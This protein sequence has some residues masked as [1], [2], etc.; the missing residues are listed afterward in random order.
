M[1]T[2]PIDTNPAYPA[3]TR[4]I[5]FIAFLLISL[6]FL[7]DAVHANSPTGNLNSGNNSHSK[8]LTVGLVADNEPY[9]SIEGR[10]ARGFSVDLLNKLS[11]TLD[12]RFDYRVGSWP[13]IYAAFL[14]GE[15]DIID[16]ISWREDRAKKILFTSPY[17]LR[18]AVVMQNSAQPLP[19]VKTLNDLKPYR[20]GILRDVY[21]SDYLVAQGI[22]VIE[23]D[24][25]PNLVQA[26]AFGW[27]DT[28]IGPEITLNYMARRDGF[29][30][31]ETHGLAPLNGLEIE[32][33]RLGTLKNRPELF[34]K[35]QAGLQSL[36]GEWLQELNDRWMQNEGQFPL[37]QEKLKLSSQQRDY[38]NRLPPLRVGL[39][40][41]YAPFS[42]SENG[43]V[44][45]L[46][47]DI[48]YRLHDLTG[49][50]FVP[51]VDQ[52]SNL[53]QLFRQ[54]DLD[55]IAN[56]SDLPE[57]RKF[58]RFTQ[59]YHR[60][61]NVAFTRDAN[62]RLNKA[63]DLS[64]LRIAVG[65][66]V[67][68]EDAVRNLFPN[69]VLSY[70][71]QSSMFKALAENQVDVVLTAL[72][73]GNHWVR[74]LGMTDTWIAGELRLPGLAGED[75]RLGMQPELEPLRAI[76]DQALISL[77]HTEKRAIEN[78]WLGA[79][80]TASGESRINLNQKEQELLSNWDYT[81]TYCV[82]PDRYPLEQLDWEN[83]HEGMSASLLTVLQQK[84]DNLR[85]DLYATNSWQETLTALEQGQCDLIPMIVPSTRLQQNLLFS[86]SWYNASNVILGNLDSPFINGINELTDKPIGISR[87]NN[88]RDILQQRYPQLKL[89]LVDDTLGGI[90]LVRQKKLYGFIGGLAETSHLLQQESLGDIRV[91]GRLPVDSNFAVAVNRQLPQLQSL[92]NKLLTSLTPK[93]LDQI[94]NDWL[95][96][97][98]EQK[99]DYTTLWQLV[100]GF[101]LLLLALFFWNRKLGN[102]NHQLTQANEQLAYLSVTDQLTELGNRSYLNQT[103]NTFI[104]Q[105]HKEGLIPACAMIDAD[106]FKRINDNHGHDVGDTCLK[107]LA[108]Q[109]RH[110]FSE[111]QDHLIRF[112][113]EEFI[114]LTSARTAEHIEARLEQL[115]QGIE[116]H[117]I[118]KE[119]L[120]LSF[121]ISIGALIRPAGE[122]ESLDLWLKAADH[123]LYKAKNG[124]RNRLVSLTDTGDLP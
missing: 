26:L 48:L 75:L 23:Y 101:S 77:S 44:Q 84:L 97:K 19:P 27:V 112:G 40:R 89:R 17:H 15:L 73:N 47:V 56:I 69:S 34:Q 121:T 25:L 49:V 22:E 35:L 52:W 85:F 20:V 100:G 31:L 96:I 67:F 79:K 104:R 105:C 13:D 29:F 115:R 37:R 4:L 114:V 118:H 95:A 76:L 16:G 7:P 106:H 119:G 57:R 111:P 28:I 70:T 46:S 124:G 1:R 122:H 8:S 90:Q 21:Y 65:K 116:K 68:Y 103:F 88:L 60:I 102:L 58:T 53:F 41:D 5:F 9:S 87:D 45:G 36:P 18:K 12:V 43:K 38:L 86:D 110:H 42:F 98:L 117:P 63:A 62:F 32:D 10:V 113:G 83:N 82:H 54:G 123:A 74:E 39:M 78:R 93:E 55:I 30:Q 94:E 72:P 50:E 108:S 3:L 6:C 81:L 66:G 80:A 64:G 2:S 14:R 109:M 71:E 99:T 91:L 120:T 24:L 51:V 107:E 61:P 92:I 11:K 33:F 59:P